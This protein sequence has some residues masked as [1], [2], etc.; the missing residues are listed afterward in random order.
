[1]LYVEEG[2]TRTAHVIELCSAA[3]AHFCMY[4]SH[5]AVAPCQVLERHLLYLQIT[6]FFHL[7]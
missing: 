1:M 5:W 7:I 2:L 6:F 3:V 4:S